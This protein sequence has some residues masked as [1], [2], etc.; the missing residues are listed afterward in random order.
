[1]GNAT[2]QDDAGIPSRAARASSFGDSAAAYAEHRPD[3]PAEA[4]RWAVSAIADKQP[5]VVLDL[6]AGTGKLTTGLLDVGAEVIAVEPDAAMRAELTRVAPGV[7]T[8]A[9]SA[10]AIPLPAR[11]VDAIIAGQAFHWFDQAAA[12]PEF[13]RVL[14]EDGVFAALWNADDNTVEWV[15]GLRQVSRPEHTDQSPSASLDLPKHPLFQDFETATFTHTQR[16]TVESLTATI[17]TYSHTL[18]ATPQRRAELLDRVTDY[19]RGRPET[20]QGEFELP[21]RTL[22]IRARLR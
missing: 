11:S 20:A 13:A 14:R 1:M 17:G 12:F 8:Y 7:T 19:L 16:R 6:G 21:L 15:A 2:D 3:Y 9:G 10:E 4:I 22:A 18:I 5:P